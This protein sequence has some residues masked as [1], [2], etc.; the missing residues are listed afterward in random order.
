MP[1]LRHRRR[2]QVNDTSLHAAWHDRVAL[3]IRALA[4]LAGPCR[5]PH[6]VT[7]PPRTAPSATVTPAPPATPAPP[8]APAS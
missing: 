1:L 8:P 4:T 6:A 3:R 2:G 5:P 7:A